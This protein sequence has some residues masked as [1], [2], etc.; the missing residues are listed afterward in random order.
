MTPKLIEDL[1]E[2]LRGSAGKPVEV[3]DAQT[4]EVY[5]LMTR[6]DFQRLVYDD[7]DLTQAEMLAAASGALDDPDG[8]GADGVESYGRDLPDS[9]AS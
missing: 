9:P 5:V 1:R 4:H 8:W 6:G 7:S 2:A 3:E